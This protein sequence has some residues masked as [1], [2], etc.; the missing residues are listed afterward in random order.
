MV[1]GIPASFL[2]G[3][4][5]VHHRRCAERPPRQVKSRLGVRP[6]LVQTTPVT[7]VALAALRSVTFAMCIRS[8]DQRV[9]V[10]TAPARAIIR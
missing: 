6:L 7:S 9:P 10:V 5:A 2:L 4:D 3:G 1:Q 8:G